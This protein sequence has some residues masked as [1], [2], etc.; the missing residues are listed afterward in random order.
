MDL[1]SLLGYANPEKCPRDGNYFCANVGFWNDQ[2]Q[3]RKEGYF[4]F[5]DICRSGIFIDLPDK[6]GYVTFP[7][8]GIGRIGYDYGA[9]GQPVPFVQYWY[10]YN[11]KDLGEVAKGSRKAGTVMPYLM[12]QDSMSGHLT[13]SCFVEEER[14]LYVYRMQAYCIG[15]EPHALVHVYHVK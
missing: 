10:F 8:V 12:S 9:S 11:P 15:Q 2:P 7:A 6:H 3:N 13:G 14:K 1:V 4:T 5:S